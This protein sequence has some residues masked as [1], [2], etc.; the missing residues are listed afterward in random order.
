MTTK[1]LDTVQKEDSSVGYLSSDSSGKERDD[2]NDKDSSKNVH[3]LR[4]V[5]VQR[6]QLDRLLSR[7]D[8]PVTIPEI[9]DKP[10]LKPPKDIV[11][12]V[13][14]SSAGAGSGEFHVYRAHRRREYTRQKIIE[15]EA[16]KEEEKREFEKKM[17]EIKHQEEVKTAKKRA[18]RQKKKQKKK[19]KISEPSKIRMSRTE[20]SMMK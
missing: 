9:Q 11:R 3:K 17:N 12:N 13:Q 5:D 18:K 8:K 2:K 15:E 16:R 6:H 7:I 4:P 10:K 20:A 1:N 19:Q 14:G